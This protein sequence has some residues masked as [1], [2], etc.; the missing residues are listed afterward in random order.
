MTAEF[1]LGVTHPARDIL[2]TA[3]LS[4][5]ETLILRRR[6]TR[7]GRRQAFVNDQR[8][9]AET[10]RGLSA[11][12]VE[13]HGQNDDRGLLDAR[14]HRVLL[15]TFAGLAMNSPRREAHGPRVAPRSARWPKLEKR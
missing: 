3:E 6:I 12:L 5:D 8:V 13:L 2:A 11:T 1:L 4:C 15:D 9:A 14:Q 7:D 10:L